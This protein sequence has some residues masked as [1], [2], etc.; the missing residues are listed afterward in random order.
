MARE[1]RSPL[2]FSAPVLPLAGLTWAAVVNYN[3]SCVEPGNSVF[4]NPQLLLPLSQ[5]VQDECPSP[6]VLNSN[7]LPSSVNLEKYPSRHQ[8]VLVSNLGLTAF[9]KHLVKLVNQGPQSALGG[10]K[11]VKEIET[12]WSSFLSLTQQKPSDASS[13][14]IENT[15]TSQDI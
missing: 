1:W 8:K 6:F 3:P 12:T 13:L 11:T 2:A 14:F 9:A 7:G 4:P 5:V 10:E 15:Y